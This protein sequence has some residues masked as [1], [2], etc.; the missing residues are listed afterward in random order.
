MSKS[1]FVPALL[2][3]SLSGCTTVPTG[4][5]VAVYPGSDKSFD[6][7]RADD[8]N[9]RQYASDQIGGP[10]AAQAGNNDAVNSGVVG[11]LIGAVAGAAIGGRDGA[12]VGAGSGLL[13]GSMAGA[14]ASDSSSY[15]MQRRYDISYQQCMYAKGNSVPVSGLSRNVIRPSRYSSYPP[16]NTPPSPPP[17]Y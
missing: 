2:F 4:P 1:I 9:C 16:P 3:L 5:Y 15:G 6:E 7:F 8:M 11:T 12:A 10:N 17:R 13:I 14:G